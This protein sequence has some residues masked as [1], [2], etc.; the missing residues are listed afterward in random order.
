[1]KVNYVKLGFLALLFICLYSIVVVARAEVVWS[2]D[3]NDGDHEGWTVA[4][5]RS[6]V[7]SQL[8]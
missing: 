2:E 3:F 6:Q 1:M 7:T 5:A 8:E 4:R